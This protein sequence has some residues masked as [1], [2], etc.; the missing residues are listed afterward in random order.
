MPRKN[1]CSEISDLEDRL[2]CLQGKYD[3]LTAELEKER[4]VSMISDEK[5]DYYQILQQRVFVL[6]QIDQIKSRIRKVEHRE[7]LQNG[8]EEVS[9]GSCVELQ[10]HIT[11]LK[12]QLVFDEEA[13]PTE[14]FISISSPIGK[15]ILGKKNGEKI[16]VQLP[17]GEIQYT[18]QDIE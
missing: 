17:N 5:G 4:A 3:Q 11:N 9:I 2:V 15:A 10:N 6:K 1:V 13:N 7:G 8:N 18:I 12:I 16:T 14:G